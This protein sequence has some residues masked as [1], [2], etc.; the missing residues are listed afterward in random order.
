MPEWFMQIHQKPF[1]M[2]DGAK[3]ADELITKSEKSL[4]NF[5]GNSWY[6]MLPQCDKYSDGARNGPGN[7][8]SRL[9]DTIVH[10]TDRNMKKAAKSLG[11]E[12]RETI[13]VVS[14]PS[15][16]HSMTTKGT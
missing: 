1:K 5:Y 9:H 2:L 15:A 7:I 6:G 10:A 3:D 4:D 16:T 11:R 8:L 14:I 13:T 12:A